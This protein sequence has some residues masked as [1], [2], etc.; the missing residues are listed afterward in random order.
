MVM[1]GGVNRLCRV[2]IRVRHIR[3]AELIFL[4]TIQYSCMA[5]NH[6]YIVTHGGTRLG[7]RRSHGM[8]CGRRLVYQG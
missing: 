5:H 3:C 6:I 4:Y 2:Q 8:H 1:V 7:F